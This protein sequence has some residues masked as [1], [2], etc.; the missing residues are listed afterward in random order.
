MREWVDDRFEELAG[1][2]VAVARSAG[3]PRPVLAVRRGTGP[4]VRPLPA[5]QGGAGDGEVA[6][7]TAADRIL[8]L[9]DRAIGLLLS[10]SEQGRLAIER[11]CI[12]TA[13]D[14][15]RF[16]MYP[17]RYPAGR[18]Q[19]QLTNGCLANLV[20][21]GLYAYRVDPVAGYLPVDTATPRDLDELDF[22][23]L[24][25]GGDE[26]TVRCCLARRG[27]P[28]AGSDLHFDQERCP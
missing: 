14:R 3:P 27:E 10:L 9:A 23:T 12:L 11:V 20:Y 17:A 8:D 19:L 7:R 4:G 21:R 16:T 26:V 6:P 5:M 18:H 24:A 25:G 28:P 13:P 2:A 22:V 1:A 15:A